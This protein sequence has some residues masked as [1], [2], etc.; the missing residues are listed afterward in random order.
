MKITEEILKAELAKSHHGN[1]EEITMS[2]ILK[3]Q[4]DSLDMM[5]FFMNLEETFEI[6]I[7]DEDVEML[8]TLDDFKDYIER[9]V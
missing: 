7:P 2:D 4:V 3:V 1:L 5:D 6:E 9:K 8:K